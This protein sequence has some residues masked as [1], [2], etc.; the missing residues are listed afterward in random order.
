MI[1]FSETLEKAQKPLDRFSKEVDFRGLSEER[2]GSG[3]KS[4]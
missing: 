2:A 1:A 3:C 4:W